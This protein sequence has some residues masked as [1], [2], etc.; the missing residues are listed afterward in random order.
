MGKP[1]TIHALG[2][3]SDFTV[4]DGGSVHILRAHSDECQNWIDEHVGDS[5][6]QRFGGGIIVESRY[7]G[8]LIEALQS[9][10]FTG[11]GI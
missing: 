3:G 5:E 11:R 10:G 6:T 4:Q 9:E 8:P 2:V 7:L 1:N